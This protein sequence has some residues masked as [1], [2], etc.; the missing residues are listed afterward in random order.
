MRQTR[1]EEERGR[2]GRGGSGDLGREALLASI[3]PL[4]RLLL[5]QLLHAPR[6]R[7]EGCLVALTVGERVEEEC[8][9]LGVEVG[10][11]LCRQ[12]RKASHK[13]LHTVLLHL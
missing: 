11:L 12:A 13:G 3:P 6:R 2:G 5:G 10:D 1:G 8:D 4:R 7:L 9:G